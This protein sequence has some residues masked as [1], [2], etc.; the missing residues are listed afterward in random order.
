MP[1]TQRSINLNDVSNQGPVRPNAQSGAA[2]GP[3]ATIASSFYL[4]ELFESAIAG[5]TLSANRKHLRLITSIQASPAAYGHAQPVSKILRRLI[6]DAVDFSPSGGLVLLTQEHR[7]DHIAIIIAD[8]S[9]GIPS[10][11]RKRVMRRQVLSS[12]R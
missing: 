9:L 6:Q 4:S 8:S 1:R 3:H 5:C 7:A 10:G 12:S 2:L 11:D